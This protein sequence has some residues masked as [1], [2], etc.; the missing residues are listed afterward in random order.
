MKKLNETPICNA[1]IAAGP[2]KGL[3][4]YEAPYYFWIEDIV[5]RDWVRRE[6]QRYGDKLLSLQ[7]ESLTEKRFKE[8]AE[9]TFAK[10]NMTLAAVS[11]TLRYQV[12]VGISN[13]LNNFCKQFE[14][15]KS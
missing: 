1:L 7:V 3:P 9:E 8:I 15:P 2:M 4:R 13:E 6:M 14:I 5:R 12:P 11:K 10:G